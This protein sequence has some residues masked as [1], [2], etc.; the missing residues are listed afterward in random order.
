MF[1]VVVYI[2]YIV[3]WPK[4]GPICWK[5]TLYM[6][7]SYRY[8]ATAVIDH[9][10]FSVPIEYCSFRF[11]YLEVNRKNQYWTFNVMKSRGKFRTEILNVVSI[12]R[13]FC[14]IA[15]KKCRKTITFSHYRIYQT[16]KS[17]LIKLH[18]P[19]SFE[20]KTSLRRT[21]FINF[22]RTLIIPITVSFT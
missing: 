17:Y 12:K 3:A 15:S 19:L 18:L 16:S 8:I 7:L 4:N 14:K 9:C 6:P 10:T 1:V 11:L 13:I 21:W 20:L 2:H 22:D 5:F